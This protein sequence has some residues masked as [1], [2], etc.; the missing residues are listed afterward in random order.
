MPVYG[1]LRSPS[2]NTA[3]SWRRSSRVSLSTSLCSCMNLV[4][5]SSSL[6][7]QNRHLPYMIMPIVDV[8]HITWR[9]AAERY[10]GTR[11]S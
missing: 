1:V 11:S 5:A 6:S 3:R 4:H 10:V 9:Q 8:D 7:D 2:V